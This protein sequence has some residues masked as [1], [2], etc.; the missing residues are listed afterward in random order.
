MKNP[1]RTGLASFGM[2][3]HVFHAPFI[4][5]NDGFELSAVVERTKDK[6]RNIYPY[7][8]VYPSYEDLLRD[9]NIELIIVNTPDHLHF[10]MTKE[11]L[12]AGKNVVVEKPFTREYREAMELT[13][14]AGKKNLLLTVFQNRRWDG[15]FLTVKKVISENLLGRLV[16]YESHFDRF[17]NE[18]PATWKEEAQTGSGALY[19]LGSHLIDQILVL[20]GRPSSVYAVLFKFRTNGKVEDNY[21]LLLEYPDKKVTTRGSLLVMEPGPRYILHGTNGSYLKWGIDPQEADLKEGKMPAGS[22][23]G[24]EDEK[25]RGILHRII[26][27]QSSRETLPTIPGNYHGFYNSLYKSIRERTEPEVKP[28]DAAFVIRIIN[29]A[30]ESQEKGRKI[31]LG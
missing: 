30:F 24:S 13:E 27:G 31:L 3:G 22:D 15:D 17:R 18:I 14:L 23:W 19:N 9:D 7:I 29:A 2:S 28:E 6:A 1:V 8:K 25:F 16:E 20:F 21:E 5:T 12:M 11:A 4:H 26:D 10:S